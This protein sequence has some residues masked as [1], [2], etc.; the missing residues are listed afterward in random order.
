M[1]MYDTFT[2]ITVKVVRCH[3]LIYA[4]NIVAW[5]FSSEKVKR[6][7]GISGLFV[8]VHTA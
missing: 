7:I 2:V 4:C 6:N 1:K 5:L 8:L 3:I